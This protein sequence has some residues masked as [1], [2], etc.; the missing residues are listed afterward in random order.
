MTKKNTERKKW[1]HIFKGER[2]FSPFDDEEL[3]ELI[4]AGEVKKYSMNEFIIREDSVDFTF[5]VILQGK[6]SIIKET[7]A[8]TNRN[9]ASLSNGHCFGEMAVLLDGHRSA[10]VLATIE[11]VLYKISGK[12]IE[13]MRME[14][15]LK[16]FR[17]FAISLAI[18]LKETSVTVSDQL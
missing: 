7:Q 8:K 14:T 1:K 4:D 9:I 2:F 10:S 6:V 3:D 12:E 5:F 11:C 18:R 17:Q 16:L 13:K 15:Q